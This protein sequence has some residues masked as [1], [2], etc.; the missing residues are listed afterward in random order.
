MYV[1]KHVYIIAF[2]CV[3]GEQLSITG[4]S[5]K[6]CVRGVLRYPA[7]QYSSKRLNKKQI[8]ENRYETSVLQLVLTTKSTIITIT[9][10]AAVE[11]MVM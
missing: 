5:K 7:Q 9:T 3:V 10:T 11:A 8:Y 2:V 1:S 4:N 6:G